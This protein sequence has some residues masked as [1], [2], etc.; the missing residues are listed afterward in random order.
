MLGQG[1][2]LGLKYEAVA[3]SMLLRF[4]C[5]IITCI[6]FC[7]KYK[8]VGRSYSSFKICATPP[9]SHMLLFC[10]LF[11]PLFLLSVQ[12]P[13]H[14]PHT[15]SSLSSQSSRSAGPNK[16]CQIRG[17]ASSS[18]KGCWTWEGLMDIQKGC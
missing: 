1:T 11:L 15:T 4:A 14:I 10:P 3:S 9:T 17:K 5:Y 13:S 2:E 12:Q 6:H 7:V 8:T 16:C 18:G